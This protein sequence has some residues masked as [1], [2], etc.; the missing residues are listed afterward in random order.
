VGTDTNTEVV[1]YSKGAW[2]WPGVWFHTCGAGG[3][4][5]AFISPGRQTGV[6]GGSKCASGRQGEAAGATSRRLRRGGW[7]RA[8]CVV[9]GCCVVRGGG[10]GIAVQMGSSL[11]PCFL[12]RGLGGGRRL[13]L[14]GVGGFFWNGQ[15]YSNIAPSLR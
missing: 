13:V 14:C 10:G 11:A 5:L 7:G 3:V 9:G 6:V 8:V 2:W 15:K 1:V 4:V 12:A